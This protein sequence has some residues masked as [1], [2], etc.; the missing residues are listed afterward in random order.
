MIDDCKY[1][2]W[3]HE[4]IVF[5]NILRK[6]NHQYRRPTEKGRIKINLG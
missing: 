1:T 4:Q 2:K 3:R 6:L 5:D